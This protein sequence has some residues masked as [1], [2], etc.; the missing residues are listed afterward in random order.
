MYALS[1]KASATLSVSV[2]AMTATMSTYYMPTTGATTA[3]YGFSKY[4][5]YTVADTWS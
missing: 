4:H 1:F 5:F 3:N 2:P